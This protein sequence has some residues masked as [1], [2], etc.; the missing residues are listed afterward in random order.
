MI[1]YI[2]GKLVQKSPTTLLMD[3]HGMGY[4]LHVSIHTAEKFQK[5]S[6]YTLWTHLHI[7]EDAHTLYGFSSL[8]EKGLFLLL[9]KINGI[10]G[11]L[12]ITVLSTFTPSVFYQLLAEKN[13]KKL[14][15]IRGIGKKIAERMV[16]ELKDKVAPYEGATM[17]TNTMDLL[18]EALQA[19]ISLG[20][21]KI[22][23]KKMLDQVLRKH[24]VDISLE[25]LVKLAL[26]AF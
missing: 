5:N 16:I 20:I 26:Q 19:L 25:K 13:I 9:I 14:S 2:H 12:A 7:R 3:V 23:A 18:E 15:S 6:F 22:E 21:K 4:L 24:Q 1:A 10:S 11:N 8:D 17:D